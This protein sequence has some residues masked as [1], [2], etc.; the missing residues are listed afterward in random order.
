MTIH[1][2]APSKNSAMV[3]KWH[4]RAGGIVHSRRRTCSNIPICWWVN[5]SL[6]SWWWYDDDIVRY[7]IC[8]NVYTSRLWTNYIWPIKH[9]SQHNTFWDKTIFGLILEHMWTAVN[10][11][12]LQWSQS[13]VQI[14]CILFRLENVCIL[15]IC[16]CRQTKSFCRKFILQKLF[17]V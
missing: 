11:S 3:K 15:K 10:L 5:L 14:K 13:I 7:D 2:L 1:F 16:F 6:I 4:R 9:N 8:Q 17:K 12:P